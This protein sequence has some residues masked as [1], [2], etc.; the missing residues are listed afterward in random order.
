MGMYRRVWLGFSLVWAVFTFLF[1]PL[2]RVPGMDEW[3][4]TWTHAPV[5]FVI[6]GMLIPIIRMLQFRRIYREMGRVGV[7]AYIAFWIVV[8]ELFSGVFEHSLLPPTQAQAVMEARVWVLV[9]LL[10]VIPMT[11]FLIH[12][13]I[14]I[15][16]VLRWLFRLLLA[17]AFSRAADE[18]PLRET[19]P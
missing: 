9:A 3:K 10:Y 13:A 11:M 6:G 17:L 2:V 1:G 5:P 14:A 4:N 15:F 12:L 7:F 16:K 8:A 19:E 18:S